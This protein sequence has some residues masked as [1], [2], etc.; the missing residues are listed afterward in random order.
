MSSPSF[1]TFVEMVGFA[2]EK[3]ERECPRDRIE[4]SDRTQMLEIFRHLHILRWRD[5]KTRSMSRNS[6]WS[7]WVDKM[8]PPEW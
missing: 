3:A 4:L 7:E 8:V 6:L 5:D 2:C 1:W